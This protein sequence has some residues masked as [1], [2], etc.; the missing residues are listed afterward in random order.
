LREIADI[1]YCASKKEHYYGLKCSFQITNE[2]FV[3]GYVVSKASVHDIRLVEELIE[4]FP[5]PYVLADIAHR[6]VG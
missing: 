5:H 1:G 4:Q 6:F 2:G 3:V